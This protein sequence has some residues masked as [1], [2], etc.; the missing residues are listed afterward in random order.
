MII[1]I[2]GV[3]DIFV[4]IVFWLFGMFGIIS[5]D[6]VLLL[7]LILLVKGLIFSIKV[8][9]TSI[10]D[11]ISSILIITATSIDLP[12]MAISLISLFLLQKGIFS[13]G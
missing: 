8:N 13:L 7:G 11:I 12:V 10:L 5:S 4:A 9:V 6:F 3:L 1:K 2:L